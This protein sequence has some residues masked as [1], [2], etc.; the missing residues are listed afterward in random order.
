MEGTSVVQTVAVGV[1]QGRS[2]IKR[3]SVRTR[4]L[5]S[6][7][8][9]SDRNHF[10]ATGNGG[11]GIIWARIRSGRGGDIASKNANIGAQDFTESE[12]GQYPLS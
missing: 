6:F 4:P 9:Y 2:L 12:V 5:S 1:R 8:F 3:I 11:S 7:R 10:A